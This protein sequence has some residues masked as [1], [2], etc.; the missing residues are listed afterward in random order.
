MEKGGIIMAVNVSELKERF[1]ALFGSS[2]EAK[3]TSHRDASTLSENTPTTTVVTY[4]RA[5]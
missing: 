5:H 4:S 3:L 2:G 1:S